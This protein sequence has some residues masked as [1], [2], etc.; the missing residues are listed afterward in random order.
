MAKLEIKDKE[1]KN[2]NKTPVMHGSP[3]GIKK[4]TVLKKKGTLKH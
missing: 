2:N 3:A 4:R 1:H